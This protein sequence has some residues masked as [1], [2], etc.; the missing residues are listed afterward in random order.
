MSAR[1]ISDFS[2][3]DIPWMAASEEEELDYELVFYR[4]PDHSG[5]HTIQ[6]AISSSDSL[7]CSSKATKPMP[8]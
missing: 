6:E 7:N 3:T 2:H 5:T 8:R 4:D 1:A